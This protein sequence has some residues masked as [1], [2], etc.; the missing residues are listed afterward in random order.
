MHWEDVKTSCLA[1]ILLLLLASKMESTI[2]A[3][4]ATSNT[5]LAIRMFYEISTTN[6]KFLGK[7]ND[8]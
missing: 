7:G 4:K 6:L 2:V 3:S 1:S 8:K 5:I